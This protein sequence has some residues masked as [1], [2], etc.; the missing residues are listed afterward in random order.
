MKTPNNINNFEEKLDYQLRKSGVMKRRVELT[1]TW[2]KNTTG[3]LL[4]NTIDGDL[5]ILEE[6]FPTG[7][8]FFH[9]EHGMYVKLNKE[10][11]KYL[12]TDAFCFY[13][14]LPAKQ[15]KA[16]DLISF[17]I[18]EIKPADISFILSVSFLITLL[19][20]LTP[21][22]NKQIFYSVIPSGSKEDVVPVLILLL[23]AAFGTA[24]FTIARNLIMTRIRDKINVNLFSAVV[25]RVFSLPTGFFKDYA[26][27]ELSTR[28][29]GIAKLSK[30]L[31]F[32]Y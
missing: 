29:M 3:V 11:S 18:G 27:G 23:G 28:V 24:L 30:I 15:L 22:I 2:W 25:L 32:F 4:G 5:V 20:L 12:E 9:K 1:G 8:K 16:S 31:S 26:A 6:T 14:A 7:Y 19:G 17:I 13:K 21:F 10:S